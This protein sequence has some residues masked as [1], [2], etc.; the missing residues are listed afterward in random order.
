MKKTLNMRLPQNINGR[1][2]A[3][4]E[5]RIYKL[6]KNRVAEKSKHN[7]VDKGEKPVLLRLHLNGSL[8]DSVT[9]FLVTYGSFEI[10]NGKTPGTENEEVG[11]T[12]IVRTIVVDTPFKLTVFKKQ[13][14]A[15]LESVK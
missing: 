1:M 2:T 4:D 5:E 10:L 11:F 8:F 3:K 9:E 14:K 7:Y 13:F 12:A 15:S 6:F